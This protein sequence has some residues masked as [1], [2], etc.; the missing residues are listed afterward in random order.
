[1]KV[2]FFYMDSWI[3]DLKKIAFLILSD[4]L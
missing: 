4:L 2:V 1:M 3:L